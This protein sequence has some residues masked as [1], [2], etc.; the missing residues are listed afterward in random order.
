MY[1]FRNVYKYTFFRIK[2]FTEG[3]VTG[4]S[5][6]S[7]VCYSG[8]QLAVVQIGRE[9]EG[10]GSCWDGS[11]GCTVYKLLC[12]GMLCVDKYLGHRQA[13]VSRRYQ[14]GPNRW[15]ESFRPQH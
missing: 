6:H 11:G 2:Y 1:S 15:P 7:S 8:L 4:Q 5:A 14:E 3:T 12:V 9:A 10:T 13:V